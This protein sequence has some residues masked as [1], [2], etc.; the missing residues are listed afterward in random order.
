M[1]SI[2]EIRGGI[3]GKCKLDDSTLTSIFEHC[4]NPNVI[5]NASVSCGKTAL[6]LA[7]NSNEN[8]LFYVIIET[9]NRGLESI[10]LIS[11]RNE[12][13]H[14]FDLASHFCRITKNYK[15]FHIEV[16]EFIEKKQGTPS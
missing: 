12:I 15:K 14:M 13:L 6:S 4:C 3:I 1:R 2:T 7:K 8:G 16:Y 11:H 5:G 10:T 9:L